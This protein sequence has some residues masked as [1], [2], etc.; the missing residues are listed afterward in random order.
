M[1]TPPLFIAWTTVA[2]QEDALRLSRTAVRQNL[3]A[4]AQIDGPIQSI[5]NWSDKLEEEREYRVTF[6]LIEGRLMDLERFIAREH[7]YE[8]P[9]FVVVRATRTAEKYLNWA[10]QSST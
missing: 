10:N 5:Y 9:E 3:V 2:Q 6:K 1:N 4:C 8:T 7:P